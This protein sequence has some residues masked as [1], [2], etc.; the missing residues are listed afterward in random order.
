MQMNTT[1][2]EMDHRMI[3]GMKRPKQPECV[4]KGIWQGA[5]FYDMAFGHNGFLYSC[6][7]YGGD[8]TREQMIETFMT[9]VMK[10]D[11]D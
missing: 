11:I 7:Y 3:S 10:H 8:K 2:L 1:G 4:L 9:G 5:K 6:R